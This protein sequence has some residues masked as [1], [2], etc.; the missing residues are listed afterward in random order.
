MKQACTVILLAAAMYVMCSSASAQVRSA[1]LSFSY[2]EFSATLRLPDMEGWILR[3]SLNLDMTRVISGESVY[4]GLSADIFYLH[5]F[6]VKDFASGERMEFYAGP[7]AS[8]GYVRNYEG[9]Y[10]IMASFAGCAG[11]EYVF[12][13]PVSLGISLEPGLGVHL[14][15][16]M[17]GEVNL[18]FYSAGF[19]NSLFPH[20]NI[21]YRF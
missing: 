14:A 4:P 6:A 10:G 11:F 17:Y 20:I 15:R 8:A 16:D 3:P 18:D 7:G 13:S 19:F 21:R 1:G 12:K 9:E 2:G 5:I